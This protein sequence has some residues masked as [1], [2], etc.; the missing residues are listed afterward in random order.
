MSKIRVFKDNGKICVQRPGGP[1]K[2]ARID[3]FLTTRGSIIWPT[4]SNPGYC[5]I[6]GLLEAPTL[7]ERKPLVLLCERQGNYLDK[8][9]ERLV[10]RAQFWFCELLFAEL[11]GDCEGYE[12][13]LY[14][15]FQ[16]RKVTGIRVYNV[17]EQVSSLEYCVNLI[18]QYKKDGALKIL[19]T[20]T[21]GEQIQKIK[22]D[23]L[24]DLQ[25]GF[26][27]IQALNQIL[28]S[29]EV[30]TWT[31]PSREEQF[32]GSGEGYR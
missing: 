26:F 32:S 2:P 7:T 1:N 23:D 30:Y 9:F 17:P 8:F 6:Y 25:E 13:S 4:A 5:A 10:E 19:P 31:K 28:V 12:T 16:S 18:K 27:G 20:S 14:R 29:F 21:V 3:V 24:K 11:G 15:F 22:L